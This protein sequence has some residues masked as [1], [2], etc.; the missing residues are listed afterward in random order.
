MNDPYRRDAGSSG[1]P[2]SW[3][4]PTAVDYPLYPDPAY[5]GQQY[6]YPTGYPPPAGPPPPT[7][8]L[9]GQP[10]RY[11]QPTQLPERDEPPP[12]ERPEPPKSRRWLWLAAG[13]AVLLVAGLVAA[14][15]INT[16]TDRQPT[17]EAPRT[18]VLGP[19]P[20]R[21]PSLTP[22]RTNPRTSP[23]RT[24]PQP[25]PQSPGT[26]APTPST[27]APAGATR[28]VVY[29]VSGEGRA[30][31]IAWIDTGGALRTDFDVALPW[32][33][34]VSLSAS[35]SPIVTVITTGGKVSCSLTVDGEQVQEFSG[36]FVTICSG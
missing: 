4:E 35:D 12:P 3:S 11:W 28:S 18:S 36:S 19:P 22:P 23:P 7:G 30:L 20:A 5:A 27:T 14:V 15:L 32:S 25:T 31:S 17:T 6:P 10:T 8:P 2:P 16:G 9:P 29:Q 26:S 1:E 24:S 21:T 33:K 13:T 34:Q